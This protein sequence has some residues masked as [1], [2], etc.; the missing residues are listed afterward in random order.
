MCFGMGG[1][2]GGSASQ[3]QTQTPAEAAAIE[4]QRAYRKTVVNRL[5]AYGPAQTDIVG[6]MIQSS[7]DNASAPNTALKR[8]MGA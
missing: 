2:G 3:T 6:S 5:N 1:G 7:N 4:A 8:L